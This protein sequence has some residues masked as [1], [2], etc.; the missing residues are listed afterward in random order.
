MVER[1][2]WVWL[3]F[4]LF[5]VIWMISGCNEK[6]NNIETVNVGQNSEH[7]TFHYNSRSIESQKAVLWGEGDGEG[8]GER[9]TAGAVVGHKFINLQHWSVWGGWWW[10]GGGRLLGAGLLQDIHTQTTSTNFVLHL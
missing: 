1:E 3:I 5:S 2:V 8:E 9:V 6:V 10:G 7:I 4:L